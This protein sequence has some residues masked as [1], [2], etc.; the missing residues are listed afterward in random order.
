MYLGMIGMTKKFWIVLNHSQQHSSQTISQEFKIT[1][2]HNL[3]FNR[4]RHHFIQR[5]KT[6]HRSMH[7]SAFHTC[8]LSASPSLTLKRQK[9]IP[10]GKSG[11]LMPTGSL[12][13][14]RHPPKKTWK[15]TLFYHIFICHI[16]YHNVFWGIFPSRSTPESERPKTNSKTVSMAPALGFFQQKLPTKGRS[17]HISYLKGEVFGKSS[18]TS[19]VPGKNKGGWYV[20]VPR[21][22]L[23][24]PWKNGPIWLNNTRNE[25]IIAQ[26]ESYIAELTAAVTRI[27][28]HEPSFYIHRN[29]LQDQ[30]A[31]ESK[32]QDLPQPL[33][34]LTLQDGWTMLGRSEAHEF[35][36]PFATQII[37]N[38]CSCAIMPYL[39]IPKP[40]YMVYINK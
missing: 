37:I 31:T 39:N 8:H 28:N 36:L 22:V 5:A 2:N 16:V 24:F 30:Y 14:H 34:I 6:L 12:H 20:M 32:H 38:L 7:T 35:L 4:L 21:S 33:L 25:E 19:K 13:C 27:A 15:N 9:H 1:Q 23:I 10:R 40:F 29:Q 18:S 26:S 11:L 3:S 17:T